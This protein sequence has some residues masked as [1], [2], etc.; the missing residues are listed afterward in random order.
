MRGARR[1]ARGA[2]L[3]ALACLAPG[4]APALAAAPA[5]DGCVTCHE[6]DI[7][8]RLALPVPEW[9]ES[10]HALHG[11]GC[12]ACHGGDPRLEDA[13]ASMS[14]A[15]G[16][17]PLPFG[18]GTTE[19]CGSCHEAL[20]EGHR[21][22]RLAAVA[23]CV[24]CHMRD[25]H[26]ILPSRPEDLMAATSCEACPGLRDPEATVSR[27]AS[28]RA[29]LDRVEARVLVVEDAGIELADAHRELA[30]GRSLL[31]GAVHRFDEEQ[32]ARAAERAVVR[33]R[34]VDARVAG[35]EEEAQGRRRFGLALL[36]ALAALAGSLGLALRNLA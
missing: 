1:S 12:D 5:D 3:A 33:F 26:R 36:A 11:V 19:P 15:A 23:T 7:D 14:P 30:G 28:A 8:A 25:G 35:L 4:L 31:A 21:S 2:L 32:I 13:D 20:A 27:L 22:G 10:V 6:A 24:T 34:E 9:R 17:V 16:F 29:V 18:G